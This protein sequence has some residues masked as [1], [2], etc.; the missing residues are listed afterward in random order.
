MTRMATW[1]VAKTIF[2]WITWDRVDLHTNI[3]SC[4]RTS[5]VLAPVPRASHFSP[6][7]ISTSNPSSVSLD[8]LP[9]VPIAKPLGATMVA[10]SAASASAMLRTT[11]SQ[12]G[13]VPTGLVE[14][15]EYKFFLQPKRRKS[16]ESLARNGICVTCSWF[17]EQ[18]V[19]ILHSLLF[20]CHLFNS[21]WLRQWTIGP[22][23][24]MFC[25]TCV[26]T[27]IIS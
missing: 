18:F 12:E 4:Y 21:T 20:S 13:P 2:P 10:T 23:T 6:A 8:S 25:L 17:F 1:Q 15:G 9:K 26:R 11:L 3:L 14:E 7:A 24:R 19:V 22:C 27:K 5:L 16:F